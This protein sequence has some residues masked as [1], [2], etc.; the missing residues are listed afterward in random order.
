MKAV[1]E[2]HHRLCEKHFAN[3]RTNLYG[4]YPAEKKKSARE[5]IFIN[6]R[7]NLYG[8]CNDERA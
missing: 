2:A 8:P 1:F 6:I 7:N 5:F 3:I 4:P